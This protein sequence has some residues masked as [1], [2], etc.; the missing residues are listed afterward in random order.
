MTTLYRV[1]LVLIIVILLSLGLNTSNKA[2]NSL[3]LG[4]Q[5]PVL[6]Y[7][8]ANEIINISIMG[9]EY[10]YSKSQLTPLLVAAENEFKSKVEY[11]ENYLKRIW[12]I[13]QAVCLP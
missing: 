7:N 3:T 4:S 10:E 8:N 13:F 12:N 1:G 9:Q 6:A 2:I 11:T 5:K